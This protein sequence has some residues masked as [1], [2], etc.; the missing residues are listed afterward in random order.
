MFFDKLNGSTWTSTPGVTDSTVLH[1]KQIALS[2]LSFPKDSI[3]K[4]VSI[5]NFKDGVLTI[6]N[7]DPRY[8]TETGPITYTYE[9]LADKGILK[10]AGMGH[11][12]LN[13]KTGIVSTGNYVLLIRSKEKKTK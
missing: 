11:A 6:L 3:H 2:K 4:N 12:V 1:S 7:Y 9:T 5:W 8:K 13:Y 10:L